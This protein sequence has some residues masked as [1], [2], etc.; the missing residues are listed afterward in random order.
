[1]AFGLGIASFQN[2]S[3]S[4]R[5]KDKGVSWVGKADMKK[6]KKREKETIAG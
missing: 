3:N 2:V 5:I 1:V 6:E 4:V